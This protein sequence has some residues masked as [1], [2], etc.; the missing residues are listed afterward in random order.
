MSP[1]VDDQT[2][3]GFFEN[4]I[5][6]VTINMFPVAL[7]LGFPLMLFIQV[8]EKEEKIME[9]LIINGLK[10][11]S[12]WKAFYT[13]NT[14]QLT[15][16]LLVFM[17]AA[18]I[19]V[20]IEYFQSSSMM[21]FFWFLTVWNLA[22]I[23]FALLVST[24]ISRSS[25]ATLVGYTVSIFLILF[26]S[27]ISQF[28]FPSP[29]NLP[30]VM[31]LIPQTPYIRFFYLGISKCVSGECISSL[32]SIFGDGELLNVV[33]MMHAN[34]AMYFVLGLI[35]NEPTLVQRLGL[36]K[37]IDFFTKEKISEEVQKKL[38]KDSTSRGTGVINMRK[39]IE[40]D[41]T[42]SLIGKGDEDSFED[43]IY[44][45]AGEQTDIHVSSVN[46]HE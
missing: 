3:K 10:T 31:Y 29:G 16:V 20:K 21:I 27:M 26:I 22:Q 46:Y 17:L 38:N 7:C 42:E 33:I 39:T 44:E 12:Y 34:A 18:K 1:T 6:L 41:L 9:L 8:M 14:L 4:A 32:G 2:Y 19:F 13:Y 11:K 40:K 25:T 30:W 15:I 28:I 24:F 43:D 23:S 37:I 35:F 45:S 5:S 36:Q